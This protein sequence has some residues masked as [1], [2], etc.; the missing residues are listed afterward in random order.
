M[1]ALGGL[2]YWAPKI[3]GRELSEGGAK[4]AFFALLL[5]V[6]L[7]AVPDLVTGALD[8]PLA[9]REFDGRD[10]IEPLNALAA[11]GGGLVVLAALIAVV[12]LVASIGGRRG[13]PAADDPWEGHTLEWATTSPPPEHN[14]VD[15]LPELTSERPLLDR[16]LAAA[17]DSAPATE[18]A[19]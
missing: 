19:S 16:R 4:L 5:G 7:L 17:A 3:W 13:D 12:N 14:F 9:A 10:A 15:E 6:L 1:A 11:A 18:A 8:Q 2:H